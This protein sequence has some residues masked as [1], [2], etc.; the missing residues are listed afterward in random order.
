MDHTG[1]KSTRPLLL[2]SGVFKD[3]VKAPIEIDL[4]LSRVPKHPQ[5]PIFDRAAV[6]VF[7]DMENF[8][9]GS[10]LAGLRRTTHK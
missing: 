4:F 2:C 10:E 5:Q 3:A 9:N 8:Q 6:K 1:A 7:D